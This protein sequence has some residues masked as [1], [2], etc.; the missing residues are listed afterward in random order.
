MAIGQGPRLPGFVDVLGGGAVKPVRQRRIAH[1]GME[2]SGM[3]RDLVLDDFDSLSMRRIH[4]FAKAGE[5]SEVLLDSVEI[6]R[7]VAMVIRDG[8]PVV[9][10]FRVQPVVVVVDGCHP[11]G[12]HAEVLQV[13]KA[14]FD[15]LEVAAVIIAGFGRI[16]EAGRNHGV[17]VGGIAVGKAVGHDEV[18]QVVL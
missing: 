13:G 15:A 3:V 14:Q 18:D 17:I 1:P 5:S 4:K 2:R 7:A 9:N 6:D 10:L 8:L 12:G 11:D 16:V